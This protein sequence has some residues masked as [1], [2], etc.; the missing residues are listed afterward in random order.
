M[1]EE[2]WKEQPVQY[3]EKNSRMEAEGLRLEWHPLER[4]CSR[5]CPLLQQ[6]RVT[7]GSAGSTL[8]GPR[9]LLDYIEGE[10][11]VRNRGSSPHLGR[12]PNGL[13]H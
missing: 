3:G 4:L 13:S 12:Y 2:L 11:R 1:V 7:V 8:F 9:M 6:H 10:R 5:S